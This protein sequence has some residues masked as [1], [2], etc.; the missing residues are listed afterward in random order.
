[1]DALHTLGTYVYESLINTPWW[2]YVIFFYLLKV[3]LS[4]RQTREVSLIKLFIVP[5]LMTVLSIE[6]FYQ[7]GDFTLL[8]TLAWL[9]SIGVGTAF[10]WWF[11]RKLAFEIQRE[12]KTVRLPGT[13]MTL[14]VLMI[15]FWSKYAFGYALG[16]EPSLARNLTFTLSMLTVSGLFTGFLLGRV[17]C[18]SFCYFNL[19][20]PDKK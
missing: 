20:Q 3:G 13:W 9:A 7:S 12:Q 18:L 10:G 6:T 16:M 19:S 8:N 1:M 17:A 5:A 11:M 14:I 2:V 15:I 4:A